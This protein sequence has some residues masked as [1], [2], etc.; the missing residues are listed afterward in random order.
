MKKFI[1]KIRRLIAPRVWAANDT[2][3][4]IHPEGSINCTAGGSIARNSLVAFSSGKVV[5]CAAS[6][7]PLGLAQDSAIEGEVLAVRLLGNASG[8]A[9]GI[10][11]EALA[12]GDPL[13]EAAG[14]KVGKTEGGYFIGYALGAASADGEVEIQHCVPQ[15]V[16]AS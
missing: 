1:E 10:A 13:Y 12:Q 8:T 11:S 6:S 15:A 16:S 3:V 4:G 5:A 7:R 2:L 14:G 9:I